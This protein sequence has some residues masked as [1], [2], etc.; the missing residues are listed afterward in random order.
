LRSYNDLS[1]TDTSDSDE[2]QLSRT[3]ELAAFSRLRSG[4]AKAS[5]AFLAAGVI[6]LL[7]RLLHRSLVTIAIDSEV[8]KFLLD[9]TQSFSSLVAELE[10]GASEHE[11]VEEGKEELDGVIR[12]TVDGKAREA[13]FRSAYPT[14]RFWKGGEAEHAWSVALSQSKS[15]RS[16]HERAAAYLNHLLRQADINPEQPLGSLALMSEEEAIRLYQDI[17]STGAAYPSRSLLEL[18]SEALQS[19]PSATAVE[20]G[21]TVIPCAE[22]EKQSDH[23]AAILRQLGAD[24]D[25]PV[26]VALP[27]SE[28]LPVVLLAILKAGSFFVPLDPTHPGQRLLDMVAECNPAAVLVTEAT[29]GIFIEAQLPILFIDEALDQPAPS[30]ALKRAIAIDPD[31]R[32]YMIYTSGSTGKP[33]GVLISQR[34]LLNMLWAT[35]ERPGLKRG[36]RLLAIASLSFDM[37]VMDMFLPLLTG[38]T[39]VI[40]DEREVKDPALLVKLLQDSDI[41]CLQATPTTWRMLLNHGWRGKAGL[42]MLSGGEALPRELA[43]RLLALPD[44]SGGELWNCYGPTE[45]TVYSS[46]LRITQDHGPVPIGPPMANTGFYIVDA[47][48]RLNP[49]EVAGELY[50]GGDGVA[51]GY[52]ERPELNEKKF[53]PAGTASFSKQRLFRTGDAARFR[54]DGSLDFFGRLDQ[55]VK[56]RGYRIELEEIES[57]LRSYPS[58]A[59]AAVVLRED[60]PGE[61]WLVAYLALRISDSGDFDGQALRAFAAQQLPDYMLPSRFVALEQLPRTGSGKVDKNALRALKTPNAPNPSRKLRSVDRT[62]DFVEAALLKVFREVLRLPSFGLDDN[63]FE[64]GGYS[65]LVVRLFARIGNALGVTL[66]ITT[67]FDAPTVRS[68]AKFIHDGNR[69]STAVP[70]RANGEEAPFFLVQSYLLYGMAGSLVPA[71]HPVIGLRETRGLR[72]AGITFQQRVSIFADAIEEKHPRGIVHLGGWCAA[73]T[74]TIEIAREL[75]SRGRRVGMIALFDA[76][77]P[78]FIQVNKSNHGLLVRIMATMRF[79]APRLRR[80]N[81]KGRCNYL[82]EWI[83]QQCLQRLEWVYTQHRGAIE[84]LHRIMPFLP[85]AVFF[86]RWTQVTIESLPKIEPIDAKVY[87][88]VASEMV[89]LPGSDEAMGW[90]RIARRGVNVIFVPG[91][92]ESMFLTPHLETLRSEFQKALTEACADAEVETQQTAAE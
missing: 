36:E 92:H 61:P 34:S 33:K 85:N 74:L 84:R 80:E 52:F 10:K 47:E 25:R 43:N 24:Q 5:R 41:Q 72:E 79:H 8:H 45:T 78:G 57:V 59:D 70:I 49:P 87:L 60:N 82:R 15:V 68:L 3:Q 89:V 51:L 18:I 46:Y 42:R 81:W 91:D 13:D 88:F 76:E 77:V 48:G 20:F 65:L 67:L 66:P 23:L 56:L 4:D 31:H 53:I 35:K 64:H 75:Q 62:V 30:S 17:N 73:S 6:V 40:A 44:G 50:I 12:M 11:R 39:L 7:G 54:P 14:F 16:D 32:A 83:R 9:P 86:N 37:S 26:V 19:E 29:A 1:D 27:R 21:Q 38:A 63:F 58:V 90:G 22:L 69:L 55:Q 71:A 28:K 2:G